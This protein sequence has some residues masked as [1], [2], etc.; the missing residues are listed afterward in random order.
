M[1]IPHYSVLVP[2]V[3]SQYSSPLFLF[4]T[5]PLW[6]IFW[7]L[8]ILAK[9]IYNALPKK[10]VPTWAPNKCCSS[11]LS[12]ILILSRQIKMC[13]YNFHQGSCFLTFRVLHLSFMLMYNLTIL[14]DTQGLLMLYQIKGFFLELQGFP[15]RMWLQRRHKTFQIKRTWGMFLAL[16]K[17]WTFK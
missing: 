15:H 17:V 5:R 1:G 7:K 3:S 8:K 9:S 4:S 6:R 13:V 16:P 10:H 12:I 14:L 2:F 11:E